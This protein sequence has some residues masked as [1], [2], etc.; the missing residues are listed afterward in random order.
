MPAGRLRRAGGALAA[1]P[2]PQ[3]LALAEHARSLPRLAVRNHAAADAGGRGA[4]LL[5]ALPRSAFPTCARWPPRRWTTCWRCGAAWAT[6]AARATC[7]AARS[8]WWS[9]RRRVPAHG[10][11][12]WRPARHRPLD[13]RGHRRLL[14]RRAR[15][16]PGRQRQARAGAR[17]G[18]RRRPGVGASTSARCGT[19]P[20]ALLPDA[21]AQE[22][23]P[24]YTQGLMDLGATVCLP[25][26]PQLPAVP[27]AAVCEGGARAGP[28]AIRSRRAS[29]AQRAVALAAAGAGGDGSVWLQKRPTPGC[30]RACIACRCSTAARRWSR[31][32]RPRAR[33]AAGCAGLRAR[34]HAQ[35]PAP[36]SGA[37]GA[38]GGRGPGKGAVVRAARVGGRW[39]CPRRCASCWPPRQRPRAG[40]RRGAGNS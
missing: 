36:A 17:A 14:L 31:R 22:N 16:H 10:R 25:R 21:R 13:G 33:P 12:C 19:T 1:Q 32:A 24:R 30:G 38:A 11:K 40:C 4:G 28:S 39:G 3:H 5:R 15:G 26:N 35:G 2:R 20:R 23:M 6:T 27:A 9:A 8:R 34:A 7:T 37:G 18:L 29:C